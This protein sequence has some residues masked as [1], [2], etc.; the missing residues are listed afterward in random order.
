MLGGVHDINDF[1]FASGSSSSSA[2]ALAASVGV[3]VNFQITN[4]FSIGPSVSWVPTNFSGGNG[5]NWQH[6]W[7]IGLQGTWHLGEW[8]H[9]KKPADSIRG[10]WLR[11]SR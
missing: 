2:D 3:G 9:D 6:N 5:N 8:L 1:S 4:S 11:N 7:S 10:D